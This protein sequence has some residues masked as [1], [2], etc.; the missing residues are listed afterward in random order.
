MSLHDPKH[1]AWKVARLAIVC[2][3]MLVLLSSGVLY[4]SNLEVK[5][6]ILILTTLVSLGGFDVA[7]SYV[8]D[9]DKQ[10]K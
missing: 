8:A 1:P 7:K 6:L 3:T 5:D 9:G 10:S 4:R 2:V